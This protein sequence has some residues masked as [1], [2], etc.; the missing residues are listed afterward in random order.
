MRRWR[1]HL[2]IG[3]S[4]EELAGKIERIIS[5]WINYYGSFYRSALYSVFNSLDLILVRWGMRKYK[6]LEGRYVRAYDWL[7]AVRRRQP[8]LFAHWRLLGF[9]AG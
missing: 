7:K 6:K 4:I 9:S 1:L 5:G 3:V 2:H 8:R